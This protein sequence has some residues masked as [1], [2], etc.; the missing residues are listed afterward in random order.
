MNENKPN[1]LRTFFLLL[2]CFVIITTAAAQSVRVSGSV[3]SDERKPLDGAIVTI[4]PSAIS[5]ITD[6]KGNFFFP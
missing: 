4:Y 1:R 3:F 5:T 6:Q 2:C